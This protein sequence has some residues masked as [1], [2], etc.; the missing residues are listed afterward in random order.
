MSAR[1]SVSGSAGSLLRRHVGRRAD[2][3][4]RVNAVERRRSPSDVA[5]SMRRSPSRSQ[6]R[7]GCRA[8]GEEHVVR[9]DVAVD[10]AALVR[11][12]E[13]LGDVA[14]N[15]DRLGD[16]QRAVPRELRAERVA[17]DEWH[18]IVRQPVALAGA[19][20]RHDVRMLKLRREQNLALEPV[21]VHAPLSSGGTTF[22]TT[23]R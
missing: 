23:L 13:R 7:D 6:I 15:G 5:R 2:D 1:W 10:D 3:V 11:V 19:Q 22:T 9:L 8:A 21:D 14:K 16:R 17:L 4:P 20:H 12:R 18:R